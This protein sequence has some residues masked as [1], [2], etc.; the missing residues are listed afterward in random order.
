V[1]ELRRLLPTRRR[2]VFASFFGLGTASKRAVRAVPAVEPMLR[3]RHGDVST[4]RI[5]AREIDL[6]VLLDDGRI[7]PVGPTAR[8]PSR[9]SATVRTACA[10]DL[11]QREK[12]PP[13]DHA[14]APDASD[15]A[16]RFPPR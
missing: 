16:D 11:R 3:R 14:C 4:H 7:V 8:M 13:P 6:A 5:G 9:S 15:E 12:G 2:A 10:A 1:S